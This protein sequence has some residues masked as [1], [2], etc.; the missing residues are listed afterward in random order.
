MCVSVGC[1]Y[2]YMHM[3]MHM[4]VCCYARVFVCMHAGIYAIT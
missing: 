3:K 4:H 2:M 1:M